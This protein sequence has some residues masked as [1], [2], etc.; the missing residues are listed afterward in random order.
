MYTKIDTTKSFI[1][2]YK[3]SFIYLWII[4]YIIYPS[5]ALPVSDTTRH[6]IVLGLLTYF[7]ISSV[8]LNRWLYSLH[9]DKPFIIQPDSWLSIIKNHSELAVV[10]LIAAILHV[11]PV[12]TRPILIIGDEALHLHGGLWI[13]KFIDIGL[14][15]YFQI[16]FWV[17]TGLIIILR[18]R[19]NLWKYICE[20]FSKYLSSSRLTNYSI[21]A[22][23]CIAVVY[24]I[25]LQ[26]WEYYPHMIRYPP[27]SR[28]MYFVL[29]S[30]F[31]I[32]HLWPRILQ[33]TFYLLGAI[34]LYRTILL[35]GDKHT[36]LFG[37][38]IF[39]FAPVTFAYSTLA[40][41]SS[42]TAMFVV[43]V[44]FY[45]LRFLEN[46]DDRDIILV[47][48]FIGA[49]FLY[50]RGSFLLV[51]ICAAYLIYCRIKDEDLNLPIHLKG[52]CLSMVPIIPW[53]IIGKYFTWRNF[54]VTLSNF[55]PPQ[56]K[57]YAYFMQIPS[58]M[59]WL[60]FILFIISIVFVFK[61]RRDHLTQ[62]MFFLF[63]SYYFL[64]AIDLGNK[65][66]RLAMVFNPTISIFIALFLSYIVNKIRWKYSFRIT[67]VILLSYV[68]ALSTVPSLNAKYLNSVEMIKLQP[69][70]SEEPMNWV[71]D[72]IKDG[73]KIVTIRIMTALYY[74]DKYQI[75]KNKIID[76][77]YVLKEIDTP[78]KLK[79]I[80]VDNKVSHIMFPYGEVYNDY[81]PI[82]QYLKE[83]NKDEFVKVTEYNIG[84]N[85]IYIYKLNESWMKT[86]I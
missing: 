85:F 25:F 14:H 24:Y 61:R 5:W 38:A 21:I 74:R 33:V 4:S 71:R 70:P 75:D 42:G 69:Y 17:L 22:I 18:T 68:I 12:V 32:D 23:F 66:P 7:A 72:N 29:Y 78:E 10:C 56:G 81:F 53:M 51:F 50:K 19:K 8:F 3:L 79:K 64:F 31:G 65:S 58:D 77:W 35:Y 82:L 16:V 73:E 1:N 27:L 11:Y 62:F 41:L 76:F 46:G 84:G 2:Q 13:Y 52:M 37:S 47:S 34:Y 54:K 26:N 36:A 20:S 44:I 59:S 49:G 40:Y 43:L 63:I 15:K 6:I 80:C 67:F 83:N 28:L 45:F 55:I 57:V 48:F 9:I 30:A 39:L 86:P 60:I